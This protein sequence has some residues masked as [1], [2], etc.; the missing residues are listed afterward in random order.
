MRL[1]DTGRQN[2]ESSTATGLLRPI[3]QSIAV[4]LQQK[5]RRSFIN[6]NNVMLSIGAKWFRE[7]CKWNR[8][9]IAALSNYDAD[10]MLKSFVL[11]IG[12]H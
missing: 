5:K 4:A 6:S 2:T 1:C 3:R 9:L 10:V 8:L 12:E 7:L 11:E